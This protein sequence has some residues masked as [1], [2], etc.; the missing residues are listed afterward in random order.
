MQGHTDNEVFGVTRNPWNPALSAGGSRGGAVD[1]IEAF[2]AAQRASLLETGT[3]LSKARDSAVPDNS[4]PRE[5]SA[6]G[7]REATDRRERVRF[8][9]LLPEGFTLVLKPP[10]AFTALLPHLSARWRC[11]ALVRDPLAILLSWNSTREHR[12]GCGN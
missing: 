10:N 6:H 9:K 7:L 5:R 3:A 8:A 1:R 4:F 2:F 12:R 11:F